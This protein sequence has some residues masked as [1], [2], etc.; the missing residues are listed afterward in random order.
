MCSRTY[1]EQKNGED[2]LG[3]EFHTKR[4]FEAV[5][6]NISRISTVHSNCVKKHTDSLAYHNKNVT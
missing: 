4:N 1:C 3:I 6:S 5:K 2:A